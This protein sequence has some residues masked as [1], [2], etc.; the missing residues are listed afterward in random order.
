MVLVKIRAI[1]VDS[2]GAVYV[3]GSTGS[4]DFPT[5]KP[6]QGSYG[7]GDTDTFIA[8]VNSSGS[9]LVYSTYLGGSDRDP[10]RGIAVDSEGAVY[11]IGNTRSVDFPT[12][13]PVQGSNAGGH[14]AFI[15]KINASGSALIYST[16]LV[17][18]FTLY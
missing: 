4:V 3:T 17:L 10:G 2:E 8:K 14:D 11:V 5:R 16:Y 13:N 15:A 7:G 18:I 12:L 6:M 1:A 9:A